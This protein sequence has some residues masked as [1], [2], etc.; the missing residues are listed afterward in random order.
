MPHKSGSM[1]AVLSKLAA[2]QLL[3]TPLFTAIFLSYL[4]ISEG[5]IDLVMPYLQVS[6]RRSAALWPLL[7]RCIGVHV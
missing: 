6:C 5:R 3:L 7:G 2:D 1:R 4:K